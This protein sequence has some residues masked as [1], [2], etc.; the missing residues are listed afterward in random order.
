MVTE[1]QKQI[2]L[3]NGYSEKQVNEME[4]AEVS[5]AIGEILRRPRT[6]GGVT[7]SPQKQVEKVEF[8]TAKNYGKIA[9]S[10]DSFAVSYAKDMFIALRPNRP[11]TDLALMAVC[12][13][14]VRFA[15]QEF[16]K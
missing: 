4:Y 9:P 12:V 2:L 8:Q 5:E 16:V 14:C 3:K 13:A 10:Y 1:K 6:N 15:Q 11:E 7:T